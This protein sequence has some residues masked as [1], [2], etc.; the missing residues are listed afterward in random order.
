MSKSIHVFAKTWQPKL[1]IQLIFLIHCCK[2]S[3][4]M[5]C[6]TY[7]YVS[8]YFYPPKLLQSIQTK[9]HVSLYHHRTK[10]CE[11][12]TRI[13]LVVRLSIFLVSATSGYLEKQY[14]WNQMKLQYTIWGCA[15]KR[16]IQ[17]QTVSREIIG[18]TRVIL[19]WFDS[20]F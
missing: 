4:V 15:W 8:L 11:R 7:E 16:I 17:D 13:T 18:I 20:Q 10:F 14:W 2:K 19:V 12:Y 6:A 5:S 3:C 1:Q 9:E